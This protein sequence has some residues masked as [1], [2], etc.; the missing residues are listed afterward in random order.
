MRAHR[1]C[2]CK[3]SL[4]LN[5]VYNKRRLKVLYLDKKKTTLVSSTKQLSGYIALADAAKKIID[6]ET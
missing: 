6:N 1:T 4:V 5:I 3:E 2:A